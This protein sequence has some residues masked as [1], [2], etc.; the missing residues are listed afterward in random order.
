MCNGIYSRLQTYFRTSLV[1]NSINYSKTATCS[2]KMHVTE[3]ELIE[4]AYRDIHSI[5]FKVTCNILVPE[6]LFFP[7]NL[8]GTG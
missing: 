6:I 1:F 7:F 8:P 2:R 4:I 3:F 5:A